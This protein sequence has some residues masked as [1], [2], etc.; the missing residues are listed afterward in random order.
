MNFDEYSK[1]AL[2]SAN[3]Y[4]DSEREVLIS[5][6]GLAGEAGEVADYLKKVYGH[7]HKMNVKKLVRELGDVLWYVNRLAVA[8]GVT[9]EDIANE[10]IVKL[11][12]RYPHGFSSEASINR[13]MEKPEQLSL[14]GMEMKKLIEDTEH[15][16]RDKF[17]PYHNGN[18]FGDP[19]DKND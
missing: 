7:G 19:N 18:L 2:R 15:T 16:C 13:P 17:C 12:E 3:Q 4:D 9:L 5:A 10:N 6:L 14:P 11:D 1:E 8:V